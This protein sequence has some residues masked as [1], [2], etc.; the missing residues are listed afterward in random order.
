MLAARS[1]LEQAMKSEGHLIAAAVALGATSIKTLSP[2]ENTL[3]REGALSYDVATQDWLKRHIE[4]GNDPLG[5]AFCRLRSAEVRREKGATYTP[6]AIV[7]AM[8]NWAR[9]RKEVPQRIV[10]PG[11]GSGR[12]LIAAAKA[13]PSAELIGV[14]VDPL[15]TLIA[16]ANLAAVGLSARATV[17][18]GDYRSLAL[19]PADG[20]TLYIGN[21]PY[22][23]HHLLEQSWKKWLTDEARKHGYSASQ[24]AGL[25]VHFFLATML[26]G[27]PGDFGLWN[28]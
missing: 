13:F 14:D 23:R 21:P 5:D 15:A 27:K 11:V 12:F 20:R 6:T 16:R 26:Q 19:P 1:K 17:L 7:R 2:A 3:C 22:V 9:S 10:D 25:H 28:E 18:L 24:L 4:K 8:V